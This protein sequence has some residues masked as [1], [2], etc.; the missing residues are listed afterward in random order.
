MEGENEAKEGVIEMFQEFII[1]NPEDTICQAIARM[2]E[3]EYFTFEEL[4]MISIKDVS[5]CWSTAERRRKVLED[6]E[7]IM[8]ALANIEEARS[9]FEEGVISMPSF[10]TRVKDWMN[11]SAEGQE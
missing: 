9:Q 1:D 7:T 2:L 11:L 8:S 4:G 6:Y 10:V 3:S 5:D